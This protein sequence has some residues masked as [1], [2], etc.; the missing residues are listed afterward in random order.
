MA[1]K[2][3]VVLGYRN[4]A[5]LL[6]GLP[7]QCKVRQG[8]AQIAGAINAIVCDDPVPNEFLLIELPPVDGGESREIAQM[9]VAPLKLG[10]ASGRPIQIDDMDRKCV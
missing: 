6:D 7:P 3:S 1:G 2:N 9:S 8:A 4:W 5:A 10:E